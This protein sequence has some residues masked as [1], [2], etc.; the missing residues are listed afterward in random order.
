M[1]Q[2]ASGFQIKNARLKALFMVDP[3]PSSVT[4]IRIEVLQMK[5]WCTKV[6]VRSP[7]YVGQTTQVTVRRKEMKATSS[8]A[9]WP[10]V[11]PQENSKSPKR[12]YLETT[13]KLSKYIIKTQVGKAWLAPFVIPEARLARDSTWLMLPSCLAII[14]HVNTTTIGLCV[15][16]LTMYT[17]Y[18]GGDP[19]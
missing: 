10:K 19:N 2:K 12:F 8:G 11:V 15:S 13:F 17:W 4:Q 6:C 14:F 1:L 5:V 3:I 16:F 18:G 7:Q 9:P